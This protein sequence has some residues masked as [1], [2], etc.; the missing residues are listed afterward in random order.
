MHIGANWFAVIQPW[1]QVT[2]HLCHVALHCSLSGWGCGNVGQLQSARTVYFRKG[3]HWVYFFC[4]QFKLPVSQIA[5]LCVPPVNHNICNYRRWCYN[6][7]KFTTEVTI[8]RVS[9]NNRFLWPENQWSINQLPEI[10]WLAQV[11]L[12]TKRTI[13]FSVSR[14]TFHICMFEW[15]S[16]EDWSGS[17]GGLTVACCLSF[18]HHTQPN[19]NLS[20]PPYASLICLEL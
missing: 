1:S 11:N 2:R 12:I 3:K 15:Q 4:D 17:F 9:W 13:N 10:E 7:A 16:C 19:A 6:L 8:R 18:P 14:I 20:S 5:S